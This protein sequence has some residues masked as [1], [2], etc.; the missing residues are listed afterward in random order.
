MGKKKSEKLGE[1]APS[2]NG[3][4][5]TNEKEEAESKRLEMLHLE[6]G[7]SDKAKSLGFPIEKI[8]CSCS[9]HLSF[10]SFANLFRVLGV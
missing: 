1:L 3:K 2:R 4:E 6:G 8:G 5:N 9:T 7:S 10:G